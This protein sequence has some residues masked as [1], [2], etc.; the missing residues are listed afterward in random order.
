M[1]GPRAGGGARRWACAAAGPAHRPTTGPPP[2]P[3]LADL[4]SLP[5]VAGV[6]PWLPR[7]FALV[8]DAAG[9]GELDRDGFVAALNALATREQRH[10]CERW[11]RGGFHRA[12]W[13]QTHCPP[14]LVPR[15][16]HPPFLPLQSFSGCLTPMATAW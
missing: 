10:D 7:V 3:A 12:A 15:P 11:W 6:L 2:P 1:P 9:A 14:A 8:C 4:Q 5:E 16:P 13:P